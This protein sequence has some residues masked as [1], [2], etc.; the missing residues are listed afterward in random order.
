[1]PCALHLWRMGRTHAALYHAVLACGFLPLLEP[2]RCSPAIS[3]RFSPTGPAVASP[4]RLLCALLLHCMLLWRP[5]LYTPPVTSS[6]FHHYLRLLYNLPSIAPL[7]GLPRLPVFMPSPSYG[8][9]SEYTDSQATVSALRIAH[10]QR[11]HTRRIA[12]PELHYPITPH[13]LPALLQAK[14][15]PVSCCA[16]FYLLK[17]G[18]GLSARCS[19]F[20]VER[21]DA[22]FARRR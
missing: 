15:L 9:S 22:Y 5:R 17:R 19:C 18:S 12:S 2:H 3:S 8:H 6:P 14:S 1:V 13:A 10:A 16:L 20:R 7:S 4:F 11:H 21:D